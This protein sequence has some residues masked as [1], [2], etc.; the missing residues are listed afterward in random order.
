VPNENIPTKRL[1]ID[2]FL[3]AAS[4][5]DAKQDVE[6]FNWLFGCAKRRVSAMVDSLG[7]ADIEDLAAT[8]VDKFYKSF[9]FSGSAGLSIE[10]KRNRLFHFLNLVI[11]HTVIDHQRGKKENRQQ[12]PRPPV[13][14]ISEDQVSQAKAAIRKLSRGDRELLDL[15]EVRELAWSDIQKYYTGA[16]KKPPSIAALKTRKHRIVERLRAQF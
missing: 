9:D 15:K 11:A 10:H 8:G 4:S 1:T 14:Q 5:E 3:E 6:L 7:S 16:R 2:D 12:Q 13:I